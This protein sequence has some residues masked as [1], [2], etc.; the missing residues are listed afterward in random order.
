M[1]SGWCGF[2]LASPPA[3]A[4]GRNHCRI[5]SREYI[6]NAHTRRLLWGGSL[7]TL[8]CRPSTSVPVTL[9]FSRLS[10]WFSIH[11]CL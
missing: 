10:L 4:L 1:Y 3:S 2:Q 8:A 5:N 9:V 7:C 6:R 11:V